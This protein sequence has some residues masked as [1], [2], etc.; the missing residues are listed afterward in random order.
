MST[1]ID[2]PLPG[3]G[4]WLDGLNSSRRL[5][6]IAMGLAGFI[7][8]ALIVR[9]DAPSEDAVV[10]GLGWLL[11][12]LRFACS[13]HTRPNNAALAGIGIL[14]FG[15]VQAARL[16]TCDLWFSKALP[17]FLFGGVLLQVS[18][19]IDGLRCTGAQWPSLSRWFQ[20]RTSSSSWRRS[21]I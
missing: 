5:A 1:A 4:T 10:A 9:R 17:F 7:H 19:A 18:S 13:K 20:P 11:V 21:P 2:S 12:V 6:I 16:E 14:L 3:I 8:M 15:L